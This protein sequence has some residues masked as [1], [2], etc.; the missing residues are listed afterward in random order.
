MVLI[1]M[2]LDRLGITNVFSCVLCNKNLESSSHLFLHYD[3]TFQCW[4][5]LFDKLNLTFVIGKDLISYFRAWPLLFAS[6]FYACLWIISPSILILNIWLERNN[7][8]FKKTSSS[9]EEILMKIKSSI[10]EVVLTY[11]F[12]NLENLSSFSHWDSTVTRV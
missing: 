3:F 1:G 10:S 12:R 2:R 4:Q 8:I 11:I 9:L 6:S 5:W 7:R